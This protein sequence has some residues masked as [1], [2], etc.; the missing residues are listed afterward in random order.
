MRG[1][2]KVARRLS[3]TSRFERFMPPPLVA[4]RSKR[5]HTRWPTARWDAIGRHGRAAMQ[6]AS[7]TPPTATWAPPSWHRAS[8]GASA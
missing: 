1:L 2:N 3:Y 7:S 5:A 8:V 4:L 6:P